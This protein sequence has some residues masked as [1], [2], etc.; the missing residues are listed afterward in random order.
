[1]SFHRIHRRRLAGALAGALA[2]GAMLVPPGWPAPPLAHAADSSG[3]LA[4]FDPTQPEGSCRAVGTGQAGGQAA[5]AYDLATHTVHFTVSLSGAVPN[6]EYALD[7]AECSDDGLRLARGDAGRLLTD[8][9]GNGTLVGDWPVLSDARDVRLT[10]LRACGDPDDP[11]IPCDAVG[12][13]SDALTPA[14][15]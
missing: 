10:L 1:M 15:R 4:R 11:Q 5:V 9:A 13:G 7:L 2:L 14:G 12:Y 8:A 3:A 6:A